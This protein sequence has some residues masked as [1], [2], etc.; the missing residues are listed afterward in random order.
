MQGYRK[1]SD[2]ILVGDS[3]V[4]SRFDA[5][6][7]VVENV[8]GSKGGEGLMAK[9]LYIDYEN[10]VLGPCTER[11]VG[12]GDGVVGDE[13]RNFGGD[14]RGA[15]GGKIGRGVSE[16]ESFGWSSE[17]NGKAKKK[18]QDS[19]DKCKNHAEVYRSKYNSRETV[20][21]YHSTRQR[22]Q[23]SENDPLCDPYFNRPKSPSHETFC[24][25]K[26][27][28]PD[29]HVPIMIQSKDA[30]G[31]T[32]K[33][34]QIVD[35]NGSKS[36]DR[37]GNSKISYGLGPTNV[38]VLK[39][40]NGVSPFKMNEKI[41]YRSLDG[42]AKQKVSMLTSQGYKTATGS[43]AKG[44]DMK[45]IISVPKGP[46]SGAVINNGR[47]SKGLA[48]RNGFGADEDTPNGRFEKERNSSFTRDAGE[49]GHRATGGNIKKRRHTEISRANSNCHRKSPL[50]P[51][52]RNL[53]MT[54]NFQ[55]TSGTN[56]LKS[57]IPGK[58][59]VHPDLELSKSV[60]QNRI[61]TGPKDSIPLTQSIKI[62]EDLNKTEPTPSL[63][64]LNTNNMIGLGTDDDKST[65][66]M[67]ARGHDSMRENYVQKYGLNV[68]VSIDSLGDS[69]LLKTKAKI[70]NSL[71][72]PQTNKGLSET[73]HCERPT[74]NL[75]NLTH[76]TIYGNNFK[77]TSK[78]NRRF[79][80]RTRNRTEPSRVDDLDQT[81]A[82]KTHK[83]KSKLND[84]FY[85][86]TRKSQPPQ[87]KS[88][89][90]P[91]SL[92]NDIELNWLINKSKFSKQKATGCLLLTYNDVLNH[93]PRYSKSIALN[94]TYDGADLNLHLYPYIPGLNGGPFGGSRPQKKNIFGEIEIETMSGNDIFWLQKK[95]NRRR[96]DVLRGEVKNLN[97]A[98]PWVN[99]FNC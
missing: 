48:W 31:V 6:G 80:Y 43:T 18:D 52:S 1:P 88:N 62:S 17:K 70:V 14:R 97:K 51:A 90:T 12:G 69:K 47:L 46:K 30:D 22:L 92:K 3:W 40:K 45:M 73:T 39:N 13:E 76:N 94:R 44:D 21:T 38:S 74:P 42:D 8:G 37:K 77:H 79:N 56:W 25:S 75:V 93:K 41:D 95:F 63:H 82:Y 16:Q 7:S 50:S 99:E 9:N 87:A 58:P 84:E 24:D 68:S 86:Q 57:I 20:R 29:K 15:L 32:T 55:D 19:Q 89:L 61:P 83:S 34:H 4:L 59:E 11:L 72:Q 71:H 53:N 5:G 35:L 23:L 78:I 66:P 26:S 98:H 65:L 91:Q 27:F 33:N 49:S 67:M 10:F 36:F 81:F 28:F 85:L 2:E 64:H 60:T 54:E 96:L